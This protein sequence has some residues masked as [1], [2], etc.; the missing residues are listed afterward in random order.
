MNKF[1]FALILLVFG[2]C[3]GTGCSSHV[4]SLGVAGEKPCFTW[5]GL[6]VEF[7]VYPIAVEFERDEPDAPVTPPTSGGA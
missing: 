4:K 2:G 6:G 7:A 3:L 5:N 1:L